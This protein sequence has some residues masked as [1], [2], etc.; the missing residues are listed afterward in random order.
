MNTCLRCGNEWE[1]KIEEPK[2]CPSCKSPLWNKEKVSARKAQEG[3]AKGVLSLRNFPDDLLRTL[4]SEAAIAGKGISE[5]CIG[6]LRQRGSSVKASP[7]LPP[8]PSPDPGRA[9]IEA[10]HQKGKK[11][12]AAPEAESKPITNL[13]GIGGVAPGSDPRYARPAH[14]PGCKCFSCCPPKGEK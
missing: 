6:I 14:A 10:F 12:V 8:A 4:K 9:V 7:L 2:Y 11:A 13:L 5:Y 1:P 3:L